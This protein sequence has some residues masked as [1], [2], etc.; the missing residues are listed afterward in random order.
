MAAHRHKK[1]YRLKALMLLSV[2]SI[3][4]VFTGQASA[5]LT[6]EANHSHVKIDFF[7]HG[8]TM[9]VRG[10]SDPDVDLIIK[11]SSP[12]GHEVLKKKGKAA[13][14]LW[15]N[16]G[17]LEIEHVPGIYFLHSTRKIDDILSREEREKYSIGYHAL[18]RHVQMTPFS[19]E[20]ETSQWFNELVKFK[21]N[22]RVYGT[23]TG[24]VSMTEKDGKGNYYI[25]TEWPYQVPPGTYTVTVYAVRDKKV[26]ETAESA[27]LVE[28]V[29]IV[30]TLAQMAK[31]NG[32]LYGIISIVIALA[33]GFGVGLVFRKGGGAH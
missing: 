18:E 21:E 6:A 26:V 5:E 10:T 31:D 16:V 3:M 24:K 29:S 2:I 13:G 25:L 7:Y 11:L 32:A 8:T 22:S 30:K 14:F 12:E 23:S 17:T 4:L 20:T 27:I 19:D 28:Q 9:S 33:A 1:N 15:M